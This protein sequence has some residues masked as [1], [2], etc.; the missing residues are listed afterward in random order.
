V[1]CALPR[2][3]LH[4]ASDMRSAFAGRRT[5]YRIVDDVLAP[6]RTLSG[7]DGQPFIDDEGYITAGSAS[8]AS[9]T[10]KDPLY[11]REMLFGWKGWSLVAPWP[12]RTV[13]PKGYDANRNPLPVPRSDEAG[14]PLPP[15]P[16]DGQGQQEE[17]QVAPSRAEGDFK[18]ETSL[19]ALPGT[20]PRLRFGRSYRLRAH[21]VDLAGNC[22][23]VVD[24]DSQRQE[25]PTGL[26]LNAYQIHPAS[27]RGVQTEVLHTCVIRCFPGLNTCGP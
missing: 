12:G 11:Y 1:R 10:T 27:R 7:P 5:Q 23:Y 13:V 4:E 19:T 26:G 18:L 20:L 8:A 22:R 2:G 16:R 6:V 17:L 21:A 14:N 25:G 15:D 3:V 9:A 24:E